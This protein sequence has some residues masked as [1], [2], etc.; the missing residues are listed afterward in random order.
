M[1]ERM[2]SERIAKSLNRFRIARVEARIHDQRLAPGCDIFAGFIGRMGF[3]VTHHNPTGLVEASVTVPGERAQTG[4]VAALCRHM[5]MPEPD[6][7]LRMRSG[8]LYWVVQEG[9]D[10]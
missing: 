10:A 1:N 5:G 9:Y 7:A 4:H 3:T 8:G 6:E 2:T